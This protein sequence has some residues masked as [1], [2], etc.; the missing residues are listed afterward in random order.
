MPFNNFSLENL[1]GYLIMVPVLLITLTVHEYSH[2]YVA[3]RLGDM[4]AKNQGRLT[5]NPFKHLDPIGTIMMIVARIGWA[6]PVPVNP[7]Y[8]RDRKKGMM[9]VSVAGP[10]SNLFMAFVAVFPMVIVYRTE[11]ESIY[12]GAGFPYYFFLFLNTFF[13]VNI[14][15]AVFNILPVPPL[16]GSKI[17]SAVLPTETYFNFMRYER[18]IGMGFLFIVLV[19]PQIISRILGFFTQPIAKSMLWVAERIVVTIM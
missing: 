13:L 5:L 15:L 6:K 18:I 3:Y 7:N 1:I 14:N 4:T 10:V 9:L 19:Y 11:Y 8:F 17:L 2:S 16:D 12:Y